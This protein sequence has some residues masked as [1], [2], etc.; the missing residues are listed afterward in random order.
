MDRMGC[1]FWISAT[2]I[3][4]RKISFRAVLM[5]GYLD[6]GSLV[7]FGIGKKSKVLKRGNVL[8]NSW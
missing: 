2:Q 4:S 8:K 6:L 5:G 7:F 1:F 3:D